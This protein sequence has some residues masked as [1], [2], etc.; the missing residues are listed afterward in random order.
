MEKIFSPY[1][2]CQCGEEHH[3]DNLLEQGRK[4]YCPKCFGMNFH[5][6][7]CGTCN[8]YFLVKGFP[9]VCPNCCGAEIANDYSQVN[10]WYAD[11][12]TKRTEKITSPM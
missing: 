5:N 8:E 9:L 1:R 4:F 12:L 2:A 3:M 6:W 11:L 7:Y 10:E